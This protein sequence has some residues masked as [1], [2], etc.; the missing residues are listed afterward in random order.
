MNDGEKGFRLARVGSA[1]A[2]AI[3]GIPTYIV[4]SALVGVN[5]LTLDGA[6]KLTTKQILQVFIPTLVAVHGGMVAGNLMLPAFFGYKRFEYKRNL[7]E[8]ELHY[9]F[10]Y[11]LQVEC[12][13]CRTKNIV[14]E[15]DP[16]TVIHPQI[17]GLK[18]YLCLGCNHTI[19]V[20][21]RE[22]S[23]AVL[24]IAHKKIVAE[25]IEKRNL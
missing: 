23:L 6:E 20:M 17:I 15:S 12:P 9:Y 8:D 7:S 1:L 25:I 18:S 5:L 16:E 10:D 22:K 2:A 24:T 11:G 14:T 21:Q 19:R 3:L 13:A 4:L